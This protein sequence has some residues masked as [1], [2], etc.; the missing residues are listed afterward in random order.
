MPDPLRIA[1]V[2]YLNAR[3]L[4]HGLAGRPDVSLS[5][6]APSALADRLRRGEADA[7]LVPSIDYFRLAADR[8]ERIRGGAAGGVVALPVAAIGSR[9]PV[10]SVRLFGYTEPKQ[11]RRVR[12][13]AE[14]RTS[15]VLA[16]LLMNRAM[17]LAPHFA[18]PD[19]GGPGT[20]PPDA[21]VMIGD[22][23]LAAAPDAA[24]WV[25]DLGEAWDH[26]VRLPFVY[27]FWTARTGAAL[28]RLAAVLAEARAAGL[29]ARP[30][31][32]RA[33]A[34]EL[35]LTSEALETYLVEMVRY[36]FGRREQKGLVA[37]YR[38]AVEDGLAPEGARLRVVDV[39]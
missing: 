13:D 1:T 23:A 7:A 28:A 38:M 9:G 33:A 36:D 35:G 18:M 10:G 5:S 24:E 37:F 32:A 34:E 31:I 17:N 39:A 4:V 20:R 25:M 22:R 30:A 6:A 12:L 3:P 8:G 16:R 14:S 11:V 21:E 2:P 19:E 26:L 15:N 29:A 27:A